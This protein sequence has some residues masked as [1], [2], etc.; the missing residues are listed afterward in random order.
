MLFAALAP[1]IA[2]AMSASRGEAWAEVCSVAGTKLVKTNF[3]VDA[4]AADPVKRQ[5]LHLEH[6]P[7]CSLAPGAFALLPTGTA[8]VIPAL[9]TPDSHPFPFFRSPRPLS[10]WT[11]AQSRAPLA[12]A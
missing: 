9:V 2:H 11:T 12:Q 10:I 1:S 6:C 5:T 7:F 3:T 4:A 8:I